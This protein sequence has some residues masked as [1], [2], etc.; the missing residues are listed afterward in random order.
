VR[1]AKAGVRINRTCLL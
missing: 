1:K